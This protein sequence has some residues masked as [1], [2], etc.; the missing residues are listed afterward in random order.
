M[1]NRVLL[2]I[3]LFLV[4]T[5]AACEPDPN[6]PAEVGSFSGRLTVHEG[7]TR[8]ESPHS[9]PNNANL[10]WTLDVPGAVAIE[11]TFDRFETENRYDFVNLLD[12]NGRIVHRLTGTL[13]G[14]TYR[15]EGSRVVFNLRSDASV[16][17]W[18]FLVTRYRYEMMQEV[19]HRPVCNA[20]GTR[21]EGWYWEDTGALIRYENCASMAAPTCGAIGS[22]SEGWYSDAGL[23]VWDNC[24][25]T[26]GIAISGEPCGPDSGLACLSDGSRTLYCANTDADGNG[27]CLDAG[28]CVI[29]QDCENPANT[30]TR[31]L[32]RGVTECSAGMCVVNCD[33]PPPGPWSWTTHLV[34]GYESAHPYADNAGVSWQ[35]SRPGAQRIKLFFTR[36]ELENGYDYLQLAGTDPNFAPV[37]LTGTYSDY[38]SP[39]IRGDTVNILLTSDSSITGWGFA[40]TMVSYYEQLPYGLCNTNADCA[41]NQICNPHHCF[42]PYAPCYGDCQDARTGGFE[43]DACS[44]NASCRDGLVCKGIVDGAGTCRSET[45]CMPQ[46]VDAD[47]AALPHIQIPGNWA[48]VDNACAWHPNSIPPMRVSGTEN[49][50]IPDN[51]P[52]GASSVATVSSAFCARP[53]VV[54]NFVIRH[55]YIGDLVVDLIDPSG[56]VLNLHNRAGGGTDDLVVSRVAYA[57][58]T[59]GI[60]GDWRLFVRDLAARDT[61]VIESFSLTFNCR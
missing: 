9:Y 31:P 50:A 38:W 52:S 26:V 61:G 19:R 13:T 8:I 2:L 30:W 34:Q 5:I 23:I 41:P 29:A 4:A 6:T 36:I 46:T 28:A 25:Q 57:P 14:N 45:W 59:T 12:E 35:F 17:R 11:V 18:G 24:H 3:S 48:C 43:G 39:E 53:E 7:S 58:H 27:T 16:R 15:V 56:T 54:V 1:E 33:N 32:C 51:N 22:R 42:N 40:A 55:T 49:V 21:S 60:A 47:C 44:T 20:I 37:R 10:S